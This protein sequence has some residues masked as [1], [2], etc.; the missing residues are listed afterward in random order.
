MRSTACLLIH[1]FG[2]APFEM[3]SLAE[4]LRGLGCR[5]SV[6]T[7]PGHAT[8]V[9]DW[10]TTGWDDWLACA[11]QEYLRLSQNHERVFVMGLSMGGSLSLALAQRH[12]P[13]GVVALAAPVYLYRFWPLDAR[14]WRLPFV[15]LLRRF[16]QVWP[17]APRSE[18]SRLMAPWEGYETGVGLDPL[19]SLIRGIAQVR[20]DLGRVTAPLLAMH[21]PRDA[22]VPVGNL[23]EIM[24]GVRSPV[25]YAVPL[26]LDE[27]VTSKHLLTTHVRCRER[28]EQLCAWFVREGAEQ[29]GR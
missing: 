25:R 18:R 19:K 23:W 12:A 28:V 4:V 21:C 9:A 14:D 20:R 10:L 3:L 24:E 5:V 7:L 15:G 16:K 11:E 17:S 22:S 8:S 26:E 13:A 2:G 27:D 29:S 6:P 1:G